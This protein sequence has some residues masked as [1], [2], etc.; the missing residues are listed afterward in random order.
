M[1]EH[2]Q[3]F[4]VPLW[5][6]A[7]VTLTVFVW[8]KSN[9]S[10]PA[11]TKPV[12]TNW[13]VLCSKYLDA[14]VFR[15]LPVLFIMLTILRPTDFLCFHTQ[16]YLK[17]R[18]K[19]IGLSLVSTCQSFLFYQNISFSIILTYL[20]YAINRIKSE[21]YREEFLKSRDMDTI[22]G[23]NPQYKNEFLKFHKKQKWEMNLRDRAF[24]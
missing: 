18:R 16:Y 3:V 2:W 9:L 19:K 22:K 12:Q 20:K 23:L 7:E 5:E 10:I 15:L 4:I 11:K 17:Q 24:A 8:V 1:T 21:K 14:R 13:L 6:K